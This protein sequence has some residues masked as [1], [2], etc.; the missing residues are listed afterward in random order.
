M[1]VKRLK[2]LALEIETLGQEPLGAYVKT[3]IEI[4]SMRLWMA[5]DEMLRIEKMRENNVLRLFE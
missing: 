4:A 2:E 5:Y 1:D 3:Q